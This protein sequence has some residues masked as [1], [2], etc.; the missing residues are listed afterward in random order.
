[1]FNTFRHINSGNRLGLWESVLPPFDRKRQGK[2]TRVA[3][4]HCRS[5]K[6]YYLLTRPALQLKC[7]EERNGCRRCRL[8]KLD[9]IYPRPSSPKAPSKTKDQERTSHTDRHPLSA[10][11][12][13]GAAYSREPTVTNE[14]MIEEGFADGN[15]KP[16]QMGTLDVANHYL[17]NGEF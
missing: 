2:L 10:G 3:C 12:H 13:V 1:M 9:C 15:H 17:W 7:T 11:S 16:D 8:K 4:T 6:V 5:K 14:L